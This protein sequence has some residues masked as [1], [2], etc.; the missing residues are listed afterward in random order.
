M[1]CVEY[2]GLY[3]IDVAELLHL[4][5]THTYT[6]A[7][8]I[9]PQK[10]VRIVSQVFPFQIQIGVQLQ[11]EYN[12]TASE[13]PSAS[14]PSRTPRKRVPD[15]IFKF[16]AEM[17]NT[18]ICT[19]RQFYPRVK[20]VTSSSTVSKEKRMWSLNRR[21]K[22]SE[23]S[24]ELIEFWNHVYEDNEYPPT[25]PSLAAYKM[26]R[27]Y[28]GKNQTGADGFTCIRS[29]I[30]HLIV[31]F[32]KMYSSSSAICSMESVSSQLFCVFLFFIYV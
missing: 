22:T 18:R 2:V 1:N 27:N 8:L 24:L 16:V 14:S 7:D 28:W 12:N 30:F 3:V 21:P 31:V 25:H 17:K 9:Q 19:Y 10:C 29:S 26:I 11:T 20:Y 13:L 5:F 6:H 32:K 15:R 4:F 23:D